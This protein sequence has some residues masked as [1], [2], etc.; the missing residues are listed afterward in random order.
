MLTEK[1]EKLSEKRSQYSFVVSKDVNKI[2]IKKA[3]EDRYQVTVEAVN[4]IVMPAKEKSRSTR[5]GL[6]RGRKPSYKKA[7]VT[8]SEGES[9]NFFGDI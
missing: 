4:T 6:I 3:V 5:A 1:S 8:L 2:E 7:I 9:I